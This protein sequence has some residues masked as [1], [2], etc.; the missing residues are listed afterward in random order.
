M[1]QFAYTCRWMHQLIFDVVATLAG[2]RK[3]RFFCLTP[4]LLKRQLIYDRTKRSF[5]SVITR[6]LTDYL[7]VTQVFVRHDYALEH[8]G[9]AADLLE[10]Y[11]R[12]VAGGK[13]PLIIDCGGNCGLATRYFCETYPEAVVV[14][15]EPDERNVSFARQN[16]RRGNIRFLLAGVGNSD[17]NANLVDPGR[18]NW[19]YQVKEDVNGGTKIVSLNSLLADCAFEDCVPFIVKIDIEGFESNLFERNTEWIDSFP[20]LVIELHDWMLPRQANSRNFLK[21]ISNRRRDFVFRD[22]N[23]FSVSNTLL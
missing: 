4:P 1:Q 12:I 9:R 17:S 16:N 15:I 13:K 2:G 22:E 10:Y 18:G 23:V 7:V 5:I 20:M 3:R 11:N 19:G 14:C 6:D 21:E 8:S